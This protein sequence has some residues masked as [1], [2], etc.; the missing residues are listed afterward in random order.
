MG[1]LL[2]EMNAVGMSPNTN[3]KIFGGDGEMAYLRCGKPSTY[4]GEEISRVFTSAGYPTDYTNDYSGFIGNTYDFTF[5][6]GNSSVAPSLDTSGRAFRGG[7]I[8]FYH[9]RNTEYVR[10]LIITVI[11]MQ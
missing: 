7:T 8:L 1:A 2:S 9:S 10:D 5:S 3:I 11:A 4:I 6:Q